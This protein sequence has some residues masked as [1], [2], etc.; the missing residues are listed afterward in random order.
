I[1]VL[2][3]DTPARAQPR[4]ARWAVPVLTQPTDG[5]P[6]KEVPWNSGP[7][8]RRGRP[9]TAYPLRPELIRLV[10]GKPR[11]SLVRPESFV[12][13]AQAPGRW[14]IPSYGVS[15]PPGGRHLPGVSSPNWDERAI[16]KAAI[17]GAVRPG[18]RLCRG[19]REW[20]RVGLSL[21]EAQPWY[22]N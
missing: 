2:S 3:A 6:I 14:C 8:P 16:S 10:A 11:T 17:Y 12:T 1:L 20:R 4:R 15:S 5:C 7:A 9:I 22:R 21:I 18:S 19:Q 13:V